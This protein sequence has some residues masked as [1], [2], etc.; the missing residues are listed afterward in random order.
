MV[1]CRKM[2][3][4]KSCKNKKDFR[5]NCESCDG[6][7]RQD[8]NR[9]YS[10][11][12]VI[13]NCEPSYFGSIC[14]YNVMVY[15]TSIYNYSDYPETP[16]IKELNVELV[17]KKKRVVKEKD[18]DELTLKVESFIK[19]N[20]KATHSKIKIVKLVK[21]ENRYYVE[22]DD[23]FCINVNR[24]H[25]SSGV[26]FQ[27]TPTGVSQRCYCKKDTLD[28]RSYGMCKHFGSPEIP[29][30]KVLQTLLF[31]NSASKNSKNK[32]IV[33]M[34]ITKSQSSKS[35]DLS[36]THLQNYKKGIVL[37]KEM[38]LLNCKS[39]LFQLEN[40]ILKK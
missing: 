4:C 35:L 24:N 17:E 6:A 18:P 34:T 13:G 22:P 16:L 32:Q 3:I 19:R 10:P 8:E 20:Y 38:C 12:A 9:V 31:G 28:G 39:I 7:G 23:N 40:E 30:T 5:E 33:N 14:N 37:N 36:T 27:I 21:Q 25:T 26:Y 29:L 11:K 2:A 15:Q 1:G